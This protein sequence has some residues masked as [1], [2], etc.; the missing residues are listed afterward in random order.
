MCLSLDGGSHWWNF[1]KTSQDQTKT[2]QEQS[3]SIPQ[4]PVYGDEEVDLHR[5]VEDLRSELNRSQAQ[6]HG[7]QTR[8]RSQSTSETESQLDPDFRDLVSRVDALE[9]QL[10]TGAR[11]NIE[12]RK[13]G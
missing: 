6:I 3:Q 10:K 13:T 1:T 12:D 7:L 9:N 11:T 5:L 2:R 4:D 8:L